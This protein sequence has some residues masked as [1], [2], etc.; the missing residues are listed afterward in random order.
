MGRQMPPFRLRRWPRSQHAPGRVPPYARHPSAYGYLGRGAGIVLCPL[1]LSLLLSFA[2][3]TA[4]PQPVLD[5]PAEFSGLLTP[6]PLRPLQA[7][8]AAVLSLRGDRES[9]DMTLQVDAAGRY[10]VRLHVPVS[11][12]VAVELRFDAERLLLVDYLA[13]RTYRAQNTSANRMRLF[14]VDLTP[15][16][17]QM[18]L[19]GRV[20]RERFAAGGGEYSP[21]QA[22][23]GE[24]EVRYVF[25]LD[26]HGLPRTWRKEQAGAVRF[27]V[28][29]LSWMDVAV[30]ATGN[31]RMPR[32]VRL[33]VDDGPPVLVLGLRGMVPGADTQAAAESISLD[34][35]PPGS[36]DFTAS[37]LP[38]LPEG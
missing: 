3:C 24:A 18:L 22:A 11:G 25:D 38:P 7:E 16:E 23:F 12:A 32:K 34:R 5:A 1:L 17:F 21:P 20:T 10:R 30:N 37:A 9:G 6:R 13:R 31:L 15:E 35:L 27:R 28:E 29:Y 14:G 36:T 4:G 8:G 2:G 33:Y 26:E 19:T